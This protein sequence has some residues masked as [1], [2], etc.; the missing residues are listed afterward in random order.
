MPPPRLAGSAAN[1]PN[2][3]VSP[4]SCWMRT[5]PTIRMS[6]RATAICR[7]PSRPSWR[8]SSG[9]RHR[10]T[11]LSDPA[12]A[13]SSSM[14]TPGDRPLIDVAVSAGSPP[15]QAPSA[16]GDQRHRRARGQAR[17]SEADGPPK[18]ERTPSRARLTSLHHSGSRAALEE[19]ARAECGCGNHEEPD[20]DGFCG[21]AGDQHTCRRHEHAGENQDR[22]ARSIDEQL[23]A[24]DVARV[25]G[26][27]PGVRRAF[28]SAITSASPSRRRARRRSSDRSRARPLG[29]SDGPPVTSPLPA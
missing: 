21:L 11:A 6:I 16:P 15:V 3:P 13:R 12:A 7:A 9:W 20:R 25:S 28:T 27:D 24:D 22:L 18:H 17:G 5:L 26:Y 8:W 19:S 14:S 23:R 10:A 29:R 4:S 1:M 2:S